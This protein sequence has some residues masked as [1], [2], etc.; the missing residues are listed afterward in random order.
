MRKTHKLPMLLLSALFGQAALLPLATQAQPICLKVSQAAYQPIEVSRTLTDGQA[1]DD[2]SFRLP[3]FTPFRLLG[4]P[5]AELLVADGY[6]RFAERAGAAPFAELAVFGTDLA[7]RSFRPGAGQGAG[8]S[9]IRWQ[10]QGMGAEQSLVLEW[11]NA[12]FF[13]EIYLLGDSRS[14]ARFQLRLNSSDNSIEIHFGPW[15]LRDASTCFYGHEGPFVYLQDL[16]STQPLLHQLTGDPAHPDL[17]TSADYGSLDAVPA[18]GTL[19]RLAQQ[20]LPTGAPSQVSA[21][22]VEAGQGLLSIRSG[23]GEG[24]VELSVLSLDG[25]QLLAHRGAGPNFDLPIGPLLPGLYLLRLT[26]GRQVKTQYL[27]VF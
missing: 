7:D 11:E 8:A 19:Y 20:E 16:R 12:G 5:V 13:E 23:F 1:W 22:R 4:K 21:T 26:D 24:P 27:S 14:H 10:L 18:T 17:A 2:P 9:P 15:E 25:R 3:M 6:V